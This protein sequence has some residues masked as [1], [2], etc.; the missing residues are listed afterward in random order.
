MNK[1]FFKN[2]AFLCI[3]DVEWFVWITKNGKN[4]NLKKKNQNSGLTVTIFERFTYITLPLIA[5]EPMIWLTWK[6]AG[7]LTIP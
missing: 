1:H 3:F 7:T 5:N 4:L 6:L 2:N